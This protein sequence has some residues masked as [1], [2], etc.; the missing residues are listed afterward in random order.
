M[1]KPMTRARSP[2]SSA[3]DLAMQRAE[4]RGIGETAA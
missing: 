4:R 1:A 2:T 3:P